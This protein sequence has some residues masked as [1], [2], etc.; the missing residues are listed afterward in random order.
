MKRDYFRN[1]GMCRRI[2]LKWGLREIGCEK[3]KWSDLAHWVFVVMVLH[4]QVL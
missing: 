1:Q 3:L 4:L 2:V